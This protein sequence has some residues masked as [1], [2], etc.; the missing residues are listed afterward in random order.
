MP[1]INF[2]TTLHFHFKKEWSNRKRAITFYRK[3]FRLRQAHNPDT[4]YNLKNDFVGSVLI[5]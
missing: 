2:H 4:L 1:M 3:L 5:T